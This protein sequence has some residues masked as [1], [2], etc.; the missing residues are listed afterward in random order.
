[1]IELY[2]RMFE[3]RFTTVSLGSTAGD[4]RPFAILAMIRVTNSYCGFSS[5]LSVA[6]LTVGADDRVLSYNM[7]GH[8]RDA[9][10][11]GASTNIVA[12]KLSANAL[13]FNLLEMS[14]YTLKLRKGVS[15][16]LRVRF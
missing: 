15:S 14:K 10:P 16:Y 6:L 3:G 2:R 11:N 8:L 13:V 9:M 5:A 7:M 4:R 1:M 12:S